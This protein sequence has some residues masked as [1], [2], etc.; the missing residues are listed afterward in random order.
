[1]NFFIWVLHK[2]RIQLNIARVSPCWTLRKQA[3]VIENTNTC[4]RS[5][6][7]AALALDAISALRQGGLQN[8]LILDLVGI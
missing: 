1:M 5:R 4:P 6:S 8:R 7:T 2:K 3:L